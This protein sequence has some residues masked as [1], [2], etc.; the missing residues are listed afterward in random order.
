MTVSIET[1]ITELEKRLLPVSGEQ[2]VMVVIIVGRDDGPTKV[3]IYDDDHGHTLGRQSGEDDAAFEKRACEWI[4]QKHPSADS[5]AMLVLIG[6]R[7][8]A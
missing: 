7:R 4:R 6:R 8:G 3:D 5:R 1:R 2:G